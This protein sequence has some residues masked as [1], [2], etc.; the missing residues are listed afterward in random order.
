[1]ENDTVFG[2]IIRGEIP[3]TKVYEDNKC[4]AF[5]DI[6]PQNK[7]HLLLIPKQQVGRIQFVP[8]DLLTHMMLKVKK[9]IVAMIK[10]LGCDY[11][12]L[13]MV[14]KGVPEHFHIHLI[15]RMEDDDVPESEYKKYDEGEMS[16]FA[17]KIKNGL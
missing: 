17:K 6:S 9:L 15:P 11:V 3:A 5:M 12:Q 14:G 13:E 1:M 8:D 16:L 10:G 2:K 4:L 7:G